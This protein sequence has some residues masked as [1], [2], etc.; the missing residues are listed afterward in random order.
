MLTIPK[1]KK[2]SQIKLLGNSDP[3]GRNS[4]SFKDGK[5]HVHLIVQ[6]LKVDSLEIKKTRHSN[7]FSSY[8]M[9]FHN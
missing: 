7:L 5:D 2:N 8:P 3:S 6:L 1:L 4:Y 9:V